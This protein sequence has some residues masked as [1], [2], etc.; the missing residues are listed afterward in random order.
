MATGFTRPAQALPSFARQTGQPCGTCHTDFP[1][2]TPFGRR[3]KLLGYTLGGG[4]F[5]TTPFSSDAPHRFTPADDAQAQT[6]QMRAYARQL[7]SGP[8]EGEKEYV[9]PISMMAIAGFTRTDSSLP[10]PTAPYAPNNNTVLSPFSGFWGGAI[11]DHI[12]AF[13]Q[14]TYNAPPVGGY[15][16]PFGRMWNWDNTDVRYANTASIGPLDFIYGIT[17]NNNPTV[18]DVWNTTPAWSFPQ[19]SSTIAPTPTAKTLI[20]GAFAAHVGG[21]GGYLF[22]NDLLY[23]EMTGYR[24]LS[25]S[26]QN[27]VG[28]DP[29]GAPGLIAQTAPYW[30][31]AIEPHWDRHSLMVGTFG[32]VANVNPWVDPTFALGSMA[33]FPQADRFTDTGFDTQYQYQGGNY[34]ITLRASYIREFQKLDASFNNGG[35]SNPTNQLNVMNLQ[36]SVAVGGDNRFVFTGQYFNVWGTSD[37][38]LYANLASGF[39]P[40]SKGFIG[41]IAYIPFGIS[42][43][44][45]WPWFNMRVGLQYTYYNEFDGTSIGAHTHNT[46]FLYTWF[47]M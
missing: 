11:T 28:I 5:K 20:Q 40:N 26:Q 19:A 24:T 23:L 41:E 27:A 42:Q 9:P 8:R 34:W 15:A 16:D 29:F 37:P 35:A 46:L 18:Q 6:E 33:T 4:A 13:A 21:V 39:S 44:P 2:L 14:V 36:G 17:A 45:G 32:M 7:E 12:G 31:A 25:F 3:F 47:A 1:F 43:A 22:I 38:L 30:R 10:P